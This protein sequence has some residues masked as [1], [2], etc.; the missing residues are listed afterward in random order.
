MITAI[1]SD[2][3]ANFEA[4]EAV[5]AALD[6]R[7][8]SRILCLGDVVG[9]GASPN[10]CVALIRERCELVLLGNHDAAA[11]GGPEA[12]RFNVHARTAA[13][14]TAKVLTLPHRDWLRALPLTQS[15]GAYLCVH[16]SPA[17]PRAWEYIFDRYDAEPQFQYF[18]E[19]VCFIGHT[20][21]P[22]AY[23]LR[24]SGCVP[25]ASPRL[26][27][28]A[29][30]RYI[31]NVGS[32]GQPR[33]RDPRASAILYHEGAGEIEFLRVAYDIEA[34]QKKILDAELPHFLATRLA[35][36]E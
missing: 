26:R 14:W 22:A 13:L 33:D 2:V 7:R 25:V 24:D 17:S 6:E 5:L 35:T 18:T 3:H 10:E 11:T 29:D 1:L 4:L 21:Q 27:L 20:H 8:P 16:A 36:G 9:Y 23:E 28:A 12:A 19:P 31:V 34:A 32:V 30:R 15:L